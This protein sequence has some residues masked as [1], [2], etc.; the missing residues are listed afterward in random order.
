MRKIKNVIPD[1]N[2]ILHIYLDNGES[3]ILDMEPMIDTIRFGLLEDESLFKRASTDGY[4]INWENKVE[5]SINELL[6]ISKGK[7]RQKIE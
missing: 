5:L 6:A 7:T 4:F 3:I 2:R 1:K